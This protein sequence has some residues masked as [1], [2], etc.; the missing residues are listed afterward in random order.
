MSEKMI[1]AC[2]NC[3]TR[4]VAPREKFLP[5]G[6]KVRCAKCANSWF[7]TIDNTEP[8]AFSAGDIRTGK[9]TATT[10]VPSPDAHTPSTTSA[11]QSVNVTD[12]ANARE[13]KMS[14]WTFG[15]R[16]KNPKTAATTTTGSQKSEFRKSVKASARKRGWRRW[17]PPLFYYSVAG[18]LILG[19]VGYAFNKPIAAKV[20]SLQ[21]ALSAWKTNVDTV[22]SK[23]IPPGRTASI[24]DVK[25]DLENT[26]AGRVLLIETVVV[27]T[28]PDTIDAPALAV[29][30]FGKDNA[31]LDTLSF[32][33]PPS[34]TVIPAEGRAPYF[35]RVENPVE[36]IVRVE[37][38]FA[39]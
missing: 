8:G 30:I 31:V 11:D 36:N 23:V 34:V 2:P 25:Y 35:L 29:E 33:A 19:A 10:A 18:S 22:V 39:E 38:D 17:I 21:P 37:V 7:H 24:L 14:S 12:T 15:A 28:G 9:Q 20:P 13:K 5:S 4:F 26:T 16:K 1:V 3:Q 32:P 27:N 6:R